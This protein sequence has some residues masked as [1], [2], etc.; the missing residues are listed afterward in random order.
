[1]SIE[2]SD[3]PMNWLVELRDCQ[4]HVFAHVAVDAFR[5]LSRDGHSPELDSYL[6]LLVQITRERDFPPHEQFAAL[7]AAAYELTQGNVVSVSI[8]IA[9][10]I[11]ELAHEGLWDETYAEVLSHYGLSTDVHQTAFEGS[12]ESARGPEQNPATSVTFVE[13]QKA[14][15]ARVVILC[16]LR[17]EFDAFSSYFGASQIQTG[18]PANRK[19]IVLAAGGPVVLVGIGDQGNVSSALATQWAIDQWHP[20]LVL[21]AGIVGG[22]QST[23]SDFALGDL[24]IPPQIV[25]YEWAKVTDRGV[26]RRLRV[27]A[28]GSRG[29]NIAT[30]ISQE[31]DWHTGISVL[32]PDHPDA[33]PKV[34]FGSLLS[35][36][37]VISSIE[38]A[39]ELSDRWPGSIG[40]EMEAA[41][42]AL[43]AYQSGSA[44]DILVAKSACDWAD[45]SKSDRY[46]PRAASVSA[47]FCMAVAIRWNQR[48]LQ[49]DSSPIRRSPRT[50]G[51]VK[52]ALANRLDNIDAKNL[53]NVLNVERRFLKRWETG[54]D[55]A[56]RVWE[57]LEDRTRLIE[58]PDKLLLIGRP[59]LTLLFYEDDDTTLALL[60]R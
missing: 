27:A 7:L 56:Q 2:C 53:A 50:D 10:I 39:G 29:L 33:L 22:I 30:A 15:P 32:D 28:A 44:P 38:V 45:A 58:L 11:A 54:D 21:L 26:E 43:A 52:N 3:S 47:A 13:A 34:H 48:H 55:I 31:T 37:K 36:E 41:G 57:W 42:L 1:L 35:G 46:H 18:I 59:D 19:Y 17:E 14:R 51:L 4:S 24:I 25:G 12:V 9:P 6:Q 60:S 40:I 16:A 8:V 23:V 49:E 20:G 5:R